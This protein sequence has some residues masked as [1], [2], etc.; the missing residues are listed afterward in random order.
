M[1]NRQW[2]LARR[3][4]GMLDANDFRWAEGEAPD[5]IIWDVGVRPGRRALLRLAGERYAT[6]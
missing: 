2:L 6:G 3:P 1:K 5:K 4:Q